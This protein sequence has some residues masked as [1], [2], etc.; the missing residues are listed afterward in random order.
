MNSNP[1]DTCLQILEDFMLRLICHHSSKLHVEAKKGHSADQYLNSRMHQMALM[2]EYL[3]MFKSSLENIETIQAL[4]ETCDPKRG[5][6]IEKIY[7]LAATDTYDGIDQRGEKSVGKKNIEVQFF[8]TFVQTFLRRMYDQTSQSKPFYFHRLPHQEQRARVQ[9]VLISLLAIMVHE[10]SIPSVVVAKIASVKPEIKEVKD[11]APVKEVV[12]VKEAI[13]EKVISVKVAPPVAP[14][15]IVS[16]KKEKI[17]SVKPELKTIKAISV[18]VASAKP[19][20]FAPIPPIS[21]SHSSIISPV[22]ALP[23]DDDPVDM[24]VKETNAKV[25]DAPGLILPQP[26]ASAKPQKQAQKITTPM[27]IHSSSIQQIQQI[28]QRSTQKI[29]V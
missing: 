10:S 22:K 11:E 1:R 17:A 3:K 24:E 8:T 15:P 2:N 16:A 27:K 9:G 23:E 29:K 25:K 28:H 13:P 21:H 14:L 12:P 6:S 4:I 7:T 5:H 19:I 26:I 20:P 18:R